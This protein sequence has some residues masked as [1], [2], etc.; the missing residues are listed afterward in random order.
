MDLADWRRRVA[1]LY[2]DVRRSADP[3]AGHA[4]WRAGR[5]ALFREHPQSPLAPDDL[6]RETGLPYAGYDPA[7][8]FEVTLDAAPAT[9][10]L[11]LSTG[12]D[13]VT[14]LLRVG[15]VHLPAPFD[16]DLDVWW[17]AQYGG[18]IFL[19]LRDGTSGRT[20]YGG[21]RYLLDTAKGADL[22]TGGVASRS[23][24]EMVLDLNFLYH[25]SCRY[26]PRWVCPL[27]PAGNRTDVDVP[28][29][30]RLAP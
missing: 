28:V 23:S 8:R 19:P 5:D 1:E 10:P 12:A 9:A 2:A 29:G 13:G 24:G 6:L 25:P 14:S 20:S 17:L 3:E 26:D 7:W 18:G 16:G 27:A 15:R 30:E 21:G 11:H 22:G 4:R